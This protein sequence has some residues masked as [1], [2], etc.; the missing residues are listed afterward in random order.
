M[1]TTADTFALHGVRC[2]GCV[3]KIERSLERLPG[4]EVARANA[5]QKRIRLVWDEKS[6]SVSTLMQAIRDLG[7]DATRIATGTASKEPSL[8]PRLAV[9][10]LGTMNI[11]AF[12]LSSWFGQATDMGPGTMQFIHWMSAG[13]A[14]PV[15]LYSGAVFHRPALRAL[16]RKKMTMDG[17]ITLAIWITFAGSLYE[18][19]RGS[20]DVYFDAVV[21]LIFF[22]LIGRV[23]EQAMGRRTDTA[24]DNLRELLNLTAHRLD[25]S[26]KVVAG[27]ASDL[28]V[29]DRI[30]V[31]SGERV[32]ADGTL[33]SERAEFDESAL[34]GETRPRTVDRDAR[35]AAGAI[36]TVGPVEIEVSHVGADSQLG[37]L[38]D[39]ADQ[40]A[41]HK[42]RMQLL[43]DRFAQ[44]Y[45]PLVL[46]GGAFG[47]L[48]WLF[49]LD[50][51]L[52]E[53]LKIAIAVLIVT[54]PCA[55]GLATPAVSSRAINLALKAGIVVKSGRALEHLADVD[56]VFIDKT[57]T[58][59]FPV[60]KPD[61][62][63]DAQVLGKARRLAATSKHP[64]ATALVGTNVVSPVTGTK[65]HPGQGVSAPDG[66]RLGNADFVGLKGKKTAGTSMYYRDPQG[67][68][69]GIGFRETPRPDL[70]PFIALADQMGLDVTLHSGDVPEAVARFARRTGI[71]SWVGAESP[72]DKLECVLAAQ[73]EGRHVLMI[74]DGINDSAALSAADVSVSF[75][76]ATDIAQSAA[77]I[78]LTRPALSLVPKAVALSRNARKLIKQNLGFSTAYN[79]LS[80]PLAL[81][82]SL[83]PALAALLMSSSSLI[84]MA[85]G[86]RLKA[87]E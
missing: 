82:G 14:L 59:S 35:V 26:G 45:I 4:V 23:L 67:V 51:S 80:V 85:N 54:C 3:L 76:G 74:G 7:Y 46:I 37:Q 5:T 79:L 58:A 66:A 55:A 71:K 84:V 2:A 47:F 61:A 18:T 42:G 48:L 16:R 32:P 53:A 87:M 33:R 77:D 49:V 62:S 64:L 68:I 9:A 36:V 81:A 75:A 12:S 43:S 21:S 19:I 30:L 78:V 72:A 70:E 28:V 34:T 83:T 52:S 17:P 69:T 86:L 27:A 8:L 10:A 73:A 40:A 44:G 50:A 41:N 15:I 13:L 24:A 20:E 25:P 6:Q 60:L 39:L 11:M 29:G 65:E 31:Q 56:Q 57:G 22:L 1:S 63:L 38:A